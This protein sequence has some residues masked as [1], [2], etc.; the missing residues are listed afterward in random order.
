M[1]ACALPGAKGPLHPHNTWTAWSELNLEFFFTV[2]FFLFAVQ[3]G[4][5]R[6]LVFQLATQSQGLPPASRCTRIQVSS[7][8]ARSQAWGLAHLPWSRHLGREPAQAT[9]SATPVPFWHDPFCRGASPDAQPHPGLLSV[10]HPSP[11]APTS[12]S[13]P[14]LASS[15]SLLH[16]SPRV[17]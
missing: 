15:S 2:S 11:P 10:S 17:L 6:W 4:L 1:K 14:S 3:V 13:L 8:Q 9:G 5:G 16:F 7:C 12:P